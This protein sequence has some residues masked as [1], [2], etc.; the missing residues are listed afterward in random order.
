MSCLVCPSSAGGQTTTGL[1]AGERVASQ[2]TLTVRTVG[3]MDV[4]NLEHDRSPSGPLAV[5]QVPDVL[6]PLL[7]RMWRTSPTF[8]RQCARLADAS[9]T[10]TVHVG[11]PGGRNNSRGLSRIDIRNGI[12]HEAKVYLMPMLPRADQLLAHEIEHVLEQIDGV[13]LRTLASNRVQGVRAH[14]DASEGREVYETSRAVAIGLLVGREVDRDE[15][16]AR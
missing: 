12:V 6:R 1:Y 3:F 15:T 2:T 9:V 11:L 10:L 4:T 14:D 5:M 8:R 13:D 16:R 7:H